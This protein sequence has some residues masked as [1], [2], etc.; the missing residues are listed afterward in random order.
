VSGVFTLS[1]DVEGLWGLFFV[2]AYLDDLRTAEAGRR[3]LPRLGAMLAERDLAATFAFVGHLLLDRCGPWE[4]LPHEHLPR[5]SYGW[6]EGDWYAHDP[7]TNEHAAPLWYARRQAL[8]LDEMGHEIGAHG[9]SHAILDE[10]SV[11]REIADV[12][13]REAQRAAAGAGLPKLASFVFPQN[14]VGHVDALAGGGFQCYREG[15]GGRP[16][17]PGP[18]GGMGRA[19]RLLKHCMAAPPP[20]GLPRIRQDGVVAIPSS[21]PFL[22]R[23]GLRRI[24]SRRARVAR[25][26]KGLERAARDDAVLHLWTHPHQFESE[27]SFDDLAAVLECVAGWRDRGEIEVLTMGALAARARAGE[28]PVAG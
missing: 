16:G 28:T 10:W 24:V 5:P 27:D 3:A 6:F 11:T 4:G 7:G 22:G 23:D 9:F 12:E 26:E 15:D 2:Q 13:M 21:L 18:P 19:L 1:V 20:V 8:A 25:I 17:R 14:V